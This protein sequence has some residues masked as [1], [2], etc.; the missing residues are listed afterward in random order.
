[1]RVV[2]QGIVNIYIYCMRACSDAYCHEPNRFLRAMERCGT[3][4]HAAAAPKSS[5]WCGKTGGDQWSFLSTAP[6]TICMGYAD[7]A[8]GTSTSLDLRPPSILQYLQSSS[9]RFSLCAVPLGMFSHKYAIA[10]F[11]VKIRVGREK[12]KKVGRVVGP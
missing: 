6:S 7:V 2:C 5:Q 8:C 4:R 9:L 12:E 1:M 11:Y 3:R 10:M